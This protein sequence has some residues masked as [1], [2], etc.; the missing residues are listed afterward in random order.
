MTEYFNVIGKGQIGDKAR[1][2]ME[3]TPLARIASIRKTA[4]YLYFIISKL[5]CWLKNIYS[6]KGKK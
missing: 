3:K 4:K 6:F 1:E 2:L 5:N